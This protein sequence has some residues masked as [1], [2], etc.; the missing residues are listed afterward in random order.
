RAARKAADVVW[1]LFAGAPRPVE[2]AAEHVE[3]LPFGNHRAIVLVT[4]RDD[5]DE[6]VGTEEV[7]ALLKELF[8]DADELGDARSLLRHLDALVRFG[9]DEETVYRLQRLLIA[10]AELVDAENHVFEYAAQLGLIGKA[11]GGELAVRIP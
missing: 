4:Q 8:V 2:A 10:A 7:S 6:R 5:G 3:A 11:L 1:V 9:I